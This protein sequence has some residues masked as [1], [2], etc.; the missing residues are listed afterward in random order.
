[1]NRLFVL[2]ILTLGCCNSPSADWINLGSRRELFVDQFLIA[3]MDGVQLRLHE[4]HREGVALRFDRPWEGGFSGYTTVIKDGP[5]YRIYYRGLPVAGRDGSENES[6][7]YAE[8]TDGITWTK[9]DLGLFQVKGTCDNNVIWTNAPFAH[10]FSPVLDERPGIPATAKFKALAGTSQTGLHAFKSGDGIHWSKLQP[11]AVFTNGVFDSQNVAFWS[12]AEQQY[13]C[14]FRTFKTVGG[15]GF[16]WVSRTT[17]KDFTH[18]D[19]PLEMEFGDTPPEHLYTNGTHPYFRAPHIY[20]ALAKRFFP[21]KAALSAEQAKALVDN[22]GY[23][24]ASSDSILMTTRGGKHYDRTFMEA[25]IRPGPG[26]EDW[27][28]RDN[29]PALG[30]VPANAHEMF[31]YRMSHYAQPSSHMARYSLR[32]DGFVS[33]NAPFRGGELVTKPFTFSGGKLKL[34]L[35]TS[36]AGGIRVEIQDANGKPIPGFALADC[37][38]M[39]GDEIGRVVSWVGGADVSTLADKPVRL[40]FVMKDADLY[41]LR[42]F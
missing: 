4:P 9:P 22:P 12:A 17:S 2:V 35:V 20:I 41:S 29:T 3:K 23:R 27:V 7:C 21:T 40:R 10:N 38:E 24:V 25:F 39:I 14:Y 18:W 15:E 31:I 42:F 16:R 5:L 28:A 33:A 30:V 32:T 26:A 36:A 6:V 13:L 1:M 34:N 37:P 8:S 11:G 19:E